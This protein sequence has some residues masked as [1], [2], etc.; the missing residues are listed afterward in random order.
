MK[1]KLAISLLL[2][3]AFTDGAFAQFTCAQLTAPDW[4]AKWQQVTADYYKNG[5]S[6]Y[7]MSE[8][9]AKIT[10]QQK[11]CFEIEETKARIAHEKQQQAAQNAPDNLGFDG[12]W[13]VSAS[14]NE[15]AELLIGFVKG[16][17]AALETLCVRPFAEGKTFDQHAY[18]A[19]MGTFRKDNPTLDFTSNDKFFTG[20]DSFYKD[21]DNRKL[22]VEYAVMY[23]KGQQAGLPAKSLNEDLAKWRKEAH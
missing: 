19:C 20:V 10:A 7:A 9:S 13:W 18:D 23:V 22:D 6:A 1:A 14:P 15:R 21:A 3:C 4:D 12:N 11:T 2:L 17:T 8:I 16:I 5:G